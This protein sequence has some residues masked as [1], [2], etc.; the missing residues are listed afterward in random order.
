RAGDRIV[1]NG[2][3]VVVPEAQHGRPFENIV[4][5]VLRGRP[6]MT[7]A[8]AGALASRLRTQMNSEFNGVLPYEIAYSILK[9]EGEARLAVRA[10]IDI[11]EN[12]GDIDRM[13]ST[14]SY[15]QG[16][17]ELLD[18]HTHPHVVANGDWGEYLG[19]IYA[20]V[21]KAAFTNRKLDG[22]MGYILERGANSDIGAVRRLRFENNKF[23]LEEMTMIDGRLQAVV[24]HTYDDVDV[25]VMQGNIRAEN[26]GDRAFE[27]RDAQR[28][29]V[30]GAVA[31]SG[32][33][34]DYTIWRYVRG[35]LDRMRGAEITPLDAERRRVKVELA[36]IREVLGNKGILADA[37]FAAYAAELL[38]LD[39]VID[40][41]AAVAGDQA[42]AVLRQLCSMLDGLA[43]KLDRI[44]DATGKTG[45]AREAALAEAAQV[46]NEAKLVCAKAVIRVM[47]DGV[48]RQ[49]AAGDLDGAAE[50]ESAVKDIVEM[51]NRMDSIQLY[52]E[53]VKQRSMDV[54]VRAMQQLLGLL[55]DAIAK[56]KAGLLDGQ[57]KMAAEL[58]R[59]KDG[60]DLRNPLTSQNISRPL[61]QAADTLVVAMDWSLLYS[62][63]AEA[64]A[65]AR[66]VRN[67][68]IARG[69]TVCIIKSDDAAAR[70]NEAKKNVAD[71]NRV[72]EN[73]VTVFAMIS[74]MNK[75]NEALMAAL[76]AAGVNAYSIIR[77]AG[78]ATWAQAL[79]NLVIFAGD[80]GATLIN[81]MADQRLAEQAKAGKL[82]IE[83]KVESVAA[84]T[85]SEF[86]SDLESE[87]AY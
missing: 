21:R 6:G 59:M 68:L 77:Q 26:A 36:R 4:M 66:R 61:V 63:D 75:G 40:L 15:R 74:E 9:G 53:L 83:A 45:A 50:V 51:L 72:S 86:L 16:D 29:M 31:E 55:A 39:G 71:K 76:Q 28:V 13:G 25:A 79:S 11:N 17:Y 49:I 80:K 41:I 24:L 70:I 48:A 52:A 5:G 46:A 84:R 69:I 56:K 87:L 81:D 57:D 33:R 7:D 14:R 35:M 32:K 3:E 19:D 58:V 54:S 85:D 37:G 1:V 23:L 82:V 64:R 43:A 30:S 65:T 22:M 38:E 62:Q 42:A 18:V 73:D 27:Y 8:R 44:S 60:I 10:V 2:V 78:A 20:M 34:M 47:R 67:L 12:T